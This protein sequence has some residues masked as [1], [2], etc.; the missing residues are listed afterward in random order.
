MVARSR[1][2][3][4]GLAEQILGRAADRLANHRKFRQSDAAIAKLDAGERQTRQAEYRGAL[5]LGHAERAAALSQPG[6]DADT[7]GV[8]AA[9]RGCSF[10][11][12]YPYD[13]NTMFPLKSQVTNYYYHSYHP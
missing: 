2:C 9:H 4:S 10:N 1:G 7:D 12:D 13:N 6:A 5:L 11:P 3:Q 8:N